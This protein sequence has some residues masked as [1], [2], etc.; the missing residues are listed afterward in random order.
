MDLKEFFIQNSK[1]ALAFSGGTDS[2]FLLYYAIKNGV[3]VLPIFIKSPFQ[4][5]FELQDAKKIASELDIELNIITID[6]NGCNQILENTEKRC[7]Y[8][9]KNIFSHLI[10]EAKALGYTTIIDGTNASDD[11]SDRPGFK[12]LLE[13]GILSPL[14]ICGITKDEVRA[15]SKKASLF[16]HNK[17]SYSCLATRVKAYMPITNELLQKIERAENLLFSL[18]FN[19]FRFRV[20]DNDTGKIQVKKDELTKAQGEII[21][22]REL[23][24]NDF[25]NITVDMEVFRWASLKKY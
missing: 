14:R 9:K 23:L 24:C 5:E 20:L 3:D 6:L 2:S 17:P 16:T 19:D 21:K 7:Y 22:I 8:C 15:L 11:I 18:E 1:V 12:A 10:E 25:K 13:Y 4:P